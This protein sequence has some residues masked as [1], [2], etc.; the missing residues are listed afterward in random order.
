[1]ALT[2]T[3]PPSSKGFS[4]SIIQET[5]LENTGKKHVR[6]APC[7]LDYFKLESGGGEANWVKFYDSD[8]DDWAGDG[9]DLPIMI[10]PVADGDEVSCRIIGGAGLSFSKGITMAASKEDGNDLVAAPTASMVVRL[11]TT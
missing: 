5:D 6:G 3:L 11:I 1:M 8:G 2:R 4:R 9:S 7:E 10:I